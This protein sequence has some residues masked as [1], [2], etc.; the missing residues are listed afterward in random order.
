[1]KT[2]NLIYLLVIVLLSSIHCDVNAQ[3]YW[4]QNRKIAL[5]PDSSHL[6][7]NIE[8][9][10]IRTPMLSSDYKGFNEISPNIIVKENKSNIFSENDFKAY[11][12]DPLVKRASPAYL[13]NGT[14]TLYVTNHILLKPK[15]GVSIDSILA[16]M[17]EI[18]EVVDQT[19]YGV[20]TLS[21][22]QG[23]DV[24]TYANIIYENGL[25]DFCHP[26]FIMRITQ[27]L[28]DPLYSEQYY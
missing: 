22:N 20:Y 3:Y 2:N 18:V 17:N 25:V 1:M 8:A 6:V 27:F 26:D 13:V 5:T 12:S 16:G 7:L 9:D 4:S 28:N 23:F 10:L 11:E 14:D 24:L 21:V 19:K 15:N